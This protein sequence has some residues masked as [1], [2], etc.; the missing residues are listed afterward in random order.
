MRFEQRCQRFVFVNDHRIYLHL[1]RRDPFRRR[2]L[3]GLKD[4]NRIVTHNGANPLGSFRPTFYSVL[5]FKD[6]IGLCIFLVSQAPRLRCNNAFIY[7][8]TSLVLGV[9]TRMKVKVFVCDCVHNF[10]QTKFK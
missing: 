10:C 1:L 8:F 9:I 7:N 3:H 4:S 5:K 2:E 6:L